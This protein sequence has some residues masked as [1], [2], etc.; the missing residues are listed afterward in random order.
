MNINN[1]ILF[2]RTNQHNM[3]QLFGIQLRVATSVRAPELPFQPLQFI[4]FKELMQEQSPGHK[5]ALQAFHIIMS[6]EVPMG[7]LLKW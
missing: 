7:K 1:L 2:S 6:L 4:P 3:V 5:I